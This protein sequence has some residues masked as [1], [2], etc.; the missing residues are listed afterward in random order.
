MSRWRGGLAWLL[1]KLSGGI[2]GLLGGW[3]GLFRGQRR[4]LCCVSGE[5]LRACQCASSSSSLLQ[6]SRLGLQVVVLRV[7]GDS[8]LLGLMQGDERGE[9]GAFVVARLMTSKPLRVSYS[10]G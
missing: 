2:E 7:S 9:P 5:G 1:E 10:G 8:G 3:G 4:V 6:A